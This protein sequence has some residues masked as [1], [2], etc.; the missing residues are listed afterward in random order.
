[1][2]WTFLQDPVIV[3]DALGR[4]FPVPS[5]YDFSLLDA[6]IKR[7]FQAGPCSAHVAAGEYEIMDTKNRSHVLTVGSFLTP[8]GSL[9]MAILVAMLPPTVSG[10]ENC[11]TPDCKSTNTTQAPGGGRLW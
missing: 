6:I 7:K 1:M 9:T 11:P 4:K 8:G 10:R 5:E 3:E 2:R